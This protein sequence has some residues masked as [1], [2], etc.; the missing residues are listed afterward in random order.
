MIIKTR[1]VSCCLNMYNQIGLLELP[2][3]I[4][5]EKYRKR[6][7]IYKHF[8]HLIWSWA[9]FYFYSYIECNREYWLSFK[10][11]WDFLVLT[12]LF[13]WRFDCTKSAIIYSDMNWMVESDEGQHLWGPVW[14]LTE[15]SKE[16]PLH[17]K[18]E[19][20]APKSS[21]LLWNMWL[22]QWRKIQPVMNA[23]K[24][25]ER[26]L[27]FLPCQIPKLSIYWLSLR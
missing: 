22:Y 26:N 27:P 8:S 1:T 12:F 24:K 20:Y 9:P 21:T 3:L 14:K 5:G 23:L 7:T 19:I 18:S 16:F 17:M 11:F 10:Y 2:I 13:S 25:M 15:Y 4:F 6:K